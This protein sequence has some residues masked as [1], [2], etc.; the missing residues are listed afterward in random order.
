MKVLFFNPRAAETKARIPN[1]ILSIA[2]TIEG[3][4][5]YAIV[6]GNL[7]KKPLR[8][9]LNYLDT[10]NYNVFACTVMPGPQLKEAI[11][12][13]K[14]I[15][16]KYPHIKSSGADILHPITTTSPLIPVML[17]T[18]FMVRATRL[19]LCYWIQ[20]KIICRFTRFQI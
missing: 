8:K 14:E 7:E 17:I 9:L 11:P 20:S 15:R 2:A 10:G 4:Y 19:F 1:S 13:T 5:D 3:K 12:F 18:S 16:K 6:D